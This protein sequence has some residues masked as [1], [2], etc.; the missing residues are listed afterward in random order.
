[1]RLFWGIAFVLV[2]VS[3]TAFGQIAELQGRELYQAAC[4]TC[5]GSDGKGSSRAVVGFDTALP[6]FTDCRFSSPEPDADWAAVITD[7]GPARS[8]DRR[9]PAF[10]QVLSEEQIEGVV[11]YLRSFCDE[12]SW[13]RGE[14]NLPRALITEK[15][16]PENEALLT[17]S[18]SRHP[19]AAVSEFL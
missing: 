3:S 15:A 7:G 17:T 8:F 6:D 4:A 5:H 12:T 1:M 9:M 18:I 10:G 14:L 13:P 11:Q 19:G 2:G 16:F